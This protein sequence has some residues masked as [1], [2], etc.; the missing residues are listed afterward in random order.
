MRSL[1][2]RKYL[3]RYLALPRFGWFRRRWINEKPNP[4]TGRYNMVEYI[5]FPW[6]VNPTLYNRWGPAA[7]FSWFAGAK[8]P[9]DDGF[10]FMPE[11][12]IA[13]DAGP[14]ASRGK[15]H[16][17]MQKMLADLDSTS[18]MLACPFTGKVS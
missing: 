8:L 9:G 1:Q 12:F 17:E 11:G 3:L 2:V 13:L 10:R 14:A 6:Y 4:K 7:W 5:S 15:G 16:D 18:P